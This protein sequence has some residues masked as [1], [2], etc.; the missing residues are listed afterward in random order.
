M[1]SQTQAN[2]DFLQNVIVMG[3]VLQGLNL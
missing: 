2:A 3:G 1:L